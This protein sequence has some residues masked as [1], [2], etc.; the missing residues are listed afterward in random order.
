[1]SQVVDDDRQ[2]MPYSEL[3]DGKGQHCGTIMDYEHLISA[4]G[5]RPRTLEYVLLSRNRRCAAKENTARPAA[6]TAHPPG[7]PIWKDGRFLWDQALEDFD[8]TKFEESEWC[9][10]NVMLIEYQ[11]EGWYERVAVGQMHETA[12]KAQNPKRKEVVLR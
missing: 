7:T 10:L 4:G 3:M 1:M 2:K 8:E 6:N 5:D 11:E 9:M 12:W